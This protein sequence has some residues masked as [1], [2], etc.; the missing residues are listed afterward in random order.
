MGDESL[1]VVLASK[2]TA[3]EPIKE[4]VEQKEPTS[5]KRKKHKH[6]EKEKRHKHKKGKSD[7]APDPVDAKHDARPA[8]ALKAS[9]AP[10]STPSRFMSLSL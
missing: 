5:E 3:E 9:S 7:G 2:S 6:K 1:G 10:H 8:E 4:P